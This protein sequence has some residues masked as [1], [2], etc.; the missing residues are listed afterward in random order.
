MIVL[1]LLH[2][3]VLFVY[4][5]IAWVLAVRDKVRYKEFIPHDNSIINTTNENS[6]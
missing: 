2:C 5:V 6:P 3:V 1:Q 4:L